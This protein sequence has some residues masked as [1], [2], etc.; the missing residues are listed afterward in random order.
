MKDCINQRIFVQNVGISKIDMYHPPNEIEIDISFRPDILL[1]ST[2]ISHN[3][4]K[5]DYHYQ[6]LNSYLRFIDWN[7]LF[8]DCTVNVAVNYV[9]DVLLLGLDYFLPLRKIKTDAAPV[10]HNLSLKK[11]KSLKTKRF[12][13]SVKSAYNIY[14]HLRRDPKKF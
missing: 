11:L 4:N 6:G 5:A 13:N 8:A 12:N 14:T 2:L 3:F 7:Y 10:W 1:S 9:N